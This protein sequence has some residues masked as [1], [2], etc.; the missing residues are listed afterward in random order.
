MGRVDPRGP[1]SCESGE[2]MSAGYARSVRVF[3]HARFGL[4]GLHVSN[5]APQATTTVTTTTIT[6]TTASTTVAPTTVVYPAVPAAN[7]E[8]S[9]NLSDTSICTSSL[10]RDVIPFGSRIPAQQWNQAFLEARGLGTAYVAGDITYVDQRGQQF[11]I[12]IGENFAGNFNRRYVANNYR[13]PLAQIPAGSAAVRFVAESQDVCISPPVGQVWV[14]LII[15]DANGGTLDNPV[16]TIPTPTTTTPGATTTTVGVPGSTLPPTGPVDGVVIGEQPFTRPGSYLKNRTRHVSGAANPCLSPNG[17]GVMGPCEPKNLSFISSAGYTRVTDTIANRCLIAD[18]NDRAT[19][20]ANDPNHGPAIKLRWLPCGDLAGSGF[21]TNENFSFIDD[22]QAPGWFLM[23]PQNYAGWNNPCVRLWDS[24]TLVLQ[25]TCEPAGAPNYRDQNWAPIERFESTPQ[26]PPTGCQ[27]PA[28]AHVLRQDEPTP[29][30]RASDL[31]CL[32]RQADESFS[33]GSGVNCTNFAPD[34]QSGWKLQ[35]IEDDPQLDLSQARCLGIQTGMVRA[36][37]CDNA[38][39]WNDPSYQSGLS[40]PLIAL[41]TQFKD[42][43]SCLGGAVVAVVVT[44]DPADPTKR[45]FDAVVGPPDPR[46]IDIYA[47][48]IGNESGL[49]FRA[50]TINEVYGLFGF[51]RGV[52]VASRSQLGRPA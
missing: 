3:D 49:D 42:T 22:P 29:L 19:G 6:T 33:I 20:Q 27:P 41:D 43:T 35:I 40:F 24:L 15:P 51:Q 50:A 28:G 25:F 11:T 8:V 4:I 12:S 9:Y 1:D 26:C 34:W 18:A 16:T 13:S 17:G 47:D 31:S 52:M 14:W 21:N 39:L 2:R 44:C 23:K 36:V 7:H 32:V 5:G 46:L 45:W 38:T 10:S 37:P 48:F 30:E